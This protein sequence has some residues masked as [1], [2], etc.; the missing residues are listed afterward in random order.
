M[1]VYH[2]KFETMREQMQAWIDEQERTGGLSR[3][4][5]LAAD[6]VV[7]SLW[8]LANNKMLPAAAFKTLAKY[9]EDLARARGQVL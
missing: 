2:P 6:M 7:R 4:V 9:T 1:P 5:K 3:E 8:T